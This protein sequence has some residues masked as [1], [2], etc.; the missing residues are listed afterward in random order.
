MG[1]R[2][3]G[4]AGEGLE[5]TRLHHEVYSLLVEAKGLHKFHEEAYEVRLDWDP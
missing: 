3:T 5:D 1:V 2:V 4:D